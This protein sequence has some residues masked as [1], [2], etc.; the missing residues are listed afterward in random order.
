MW[1]LAARR[2]GEPLWRY[3][4]GTPT[5]NVYASGISPGQVEELA[6]RAVRNGHR[7]AKL[8]VGFGSQE[9]RANVAMLRSVLGDAGTLM[10]DANQRWTL[11][12]AAP[13]IGQLADFRLE[14]IE[15]PMAADAPVSA[16]QSLSRVSPVPLAAGENL[17]GVAQ[18]DEFVR[19]A[20]LRFLQ[21]DMGKW[22]GFTE[23]VPLGRRAIAAGLRFCPHWLGGGIG[24]LASL[25][26]LGAVGAQ[27]WGEVDA[28]PNPLQ[29]RLLPADFN[30]RAGQLTL[31][32]APGLGYEPEPAVIE[33]FR[34][35]I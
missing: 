33:E 7:A 27:G 31:A 19:S 13:A 22:G 5:L 2:A 9:D 24:L 26:L 1:D 17:R 4:G 10:L 21:P 14:W 16:W 25:H 12:E 15:E 34:V 3:F 8:K 23:C 20:A 28:N 35:K 29:Q 18:F 30:V 32:D 11:E 6:T